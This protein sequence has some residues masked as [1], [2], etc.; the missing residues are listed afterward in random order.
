MS[1]VTRTDIVAEARRWLGTPWQHQQRLRGQ[2]VD[3]VGLV[4]GVARSVGLVPPD[5]DVTG[6]GRTPDGTLLQLCDQHLQRI[7]RAALQP[8]DVVAVAMDVDPQHL[9]IVAD[10]RHGGLSVIHAAS[11]HGRVVEHRL[12]FDRAFLFRAAYSMLEIH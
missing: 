2:A 12:M 5:W 10:Y 8:G 1:T 4:I 3:C 9:G 7:D 6:Y 11:H